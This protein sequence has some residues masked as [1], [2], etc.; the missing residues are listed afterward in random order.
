MAPPSPRRP[1]FSK[2]AQLGL[3]AGYVVAVTGGLLG[4]LLVVTAQVD[5]AGNAGIQTVLSDIFSPISRTG[6]AVVTAMRDGGE[7]FSA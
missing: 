6:R 3:F 5:P 4:L 2:R 1:G 7:S